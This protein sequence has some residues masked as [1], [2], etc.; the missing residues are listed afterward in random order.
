MRR[1]VGR[2]FPIVAGGLGIAVVLVVCVPETLAFPHRRTI[3]DTVIWSEAPVAPALDIILDRAEARLRA[4][5]IRGQGRQRL[6]LTDGGWRWKVLALRSAGAFAVT[7][8]IGDPIVINRSDPTS[9]LV[10]NGRAVAGQRSLSGVVAHERTHGWI[11]ARYGPMADM[12]YPTWLVEG[13]ADVVAGGG[14]LSDA[15]AVRLRH[16]DPAAP[17]LLYYDGRKRVEAALRANGGD[18]AALFAAHDRL[19]WR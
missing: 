15:D 7:R 10:F 13:Y 12:R 4:N 19:R 3:G 11:R 8:P 16:S 5:G 6:F 17:A 1:R 18:V 14:S 2:W 9:D